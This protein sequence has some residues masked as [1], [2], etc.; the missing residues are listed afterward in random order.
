MIAL[1][2]AFLLKLRAL[3][4]EG[5]CDYR[6]SDINSA[7]KHLKNDRLELVDQTTSI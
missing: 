1:A 4:L 5:I 6:N 7:A 3:L 2:D